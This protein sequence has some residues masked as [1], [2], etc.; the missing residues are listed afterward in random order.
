MSES[1]YGFTW[2]II[3]PRGKITLTVE[4]GKEP[5]IA[6][7]FM[8]FLIIDRRS[9]YN[10]LGCPA[11]KQLMA[12]TSIHHL[13]MKFLTSAGVATIKENQEL[14]RECY[15]NALRNEALRAPIADIVMMTETSTNA[16][17]ENEMELSHMEHESKPGVED[18]LFLSGTDQLA[19]L[20]AMYALTFRSNKDYN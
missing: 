13:A 19:D 7:N 18:N 5:L 2:D 15:L 20:T 1:L 8:E 12:V 4:V 14:A 9:A 17:V 6:R 3:N 16:G 10:G 11:L